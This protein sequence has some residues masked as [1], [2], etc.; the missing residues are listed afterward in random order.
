ML[1]DVRGSGRGQY[2]KGYV[3]DIVS[4]RHVFSKRELDP[5]L[6]C[7]VLVPDAEPAELAAL[8]TEGSNTRRAVRMP[9]V[10]VDNIRFSN[11]TP[12]RATINR[13][14]LNSKIEAVSVTTRIMQRVARFVGLR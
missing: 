7:I 8:L 3:V 9:A 14:T 11:T 10:E 2:L 12:G 13:A 1:R 5:A 4:E 6:F